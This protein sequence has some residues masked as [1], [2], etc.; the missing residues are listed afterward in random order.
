[1]TLNHCPALLGDCDEL[2]VCMLVNRLAALTAYFNSSR[3][4]LYG[5]WHVN[6]LA[7]ALMNCIRLSALAACCPG[8]V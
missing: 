2:A 6:D 5:R 3:D 1:M 7:F 4:T 8:A